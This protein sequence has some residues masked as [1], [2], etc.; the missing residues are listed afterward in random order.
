[1]EDSRVLIVGDPLGTR[2]T[3]SADDVEFVRDPTGVLGQ[4][5]FSAGAD[6]DASLPDDAIDSGYRR[7]E[8]WLWHRP[9]DPSA[10]W[11]VSPDGVE[12]WPAGRPPACS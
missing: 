12:R 4:P 2:Y 10:I 7:G 6:P 11:L 1:L 8:V 5:E 3:T 9:G